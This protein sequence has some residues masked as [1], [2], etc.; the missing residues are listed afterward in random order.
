MEHMQP[1]LGALATADAR[2]CTHGACHSKTTEICSRTEE[3]QDRDM[4][5]RFRAIY[6]TAD[7]SQW[8]VIDTKHGLI[9][10]PTID[11]QVPRVGPL[12]FYF[13]SCYELKPPKEAGEEGVYEM[14]PEADVKATIAAEIL[15]IVSEY[16][17]ETITASPKMQEMNERLTELVLTRRKETMI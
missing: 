2:G 9:T 7:L 10:P 13:A 4:T 1:S 8:A 14:R 17:G 12:T 16:G 3:R 15:T 6:V 5:D 11:F